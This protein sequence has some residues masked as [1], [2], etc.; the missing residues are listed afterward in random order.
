MTTD[1]G[2]RR[3]YKTP[4]A[5]HFPDRLSFPE[6]EKALSLRYGE[7]P[8]QPAAFYRQTDARGATMAHFDVL[9]EG[10]GLGYINLADMNVGQRVVERLVDIYGPHRRMCCI[11]KHEIPAGVALG[12]D[13]DSAFEKAWE[14]DPLSVFGGVHVF[15]GTVEASLAEKLL[16]KG[17]NAE[18]VYAP[19]FSPDALTIFQRRKDLRVIMRNDFSPAEDGGLDYKRVIGGMLV[20]QRF[21][22]RINL[23]FDLECVSEVQPTPDQ[24]A[25]A[26]FNW[27]V[28]CFTRSNAV[29]IG[30]HFQTHGIGAGQQSRIDAAYMAVR[31]ANGRDGASKGLGARGTF[32]ASDAFMP[33]PDVVELAAEHGVCGIVYPLG[34][35]KDQ[36]VIDAANKH[37]L[38]MLVTGRPGLEPPYERCFSH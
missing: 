4:V 32:M 17:R 37:G 28:A 38:V 1:Q 7:N 26:I 6:F 16:E 2:A 12:S 15:S 19:S 30:S 34:S 21:R 9:Q 29:V 31:K 11:I 14:C 27:N 36:E 22:S 18:V 24:Y 25:A 8:G 10:K 33:E 23:P 35:I 20:Q 13:V 5:E 3:Q